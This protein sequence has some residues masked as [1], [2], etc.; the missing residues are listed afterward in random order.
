MQRV[1]PPP[2]PRNMDQAWHGWLRERGEATATRAGTL[3]MWGGAAHAAYCVAV[4]AP[5]RVGV[6]RRSAPR[7][8]VSGGR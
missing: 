1:A 5:L 7:A 4:P 2:P 6:V 3:F 8:M